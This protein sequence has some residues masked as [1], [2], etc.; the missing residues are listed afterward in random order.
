MFL[1]LL[2][3]ATLIAHV[4]AG[5]PKGYEEAMLELQKA[6][7]TGND[8]AVAASVEDFVNLLPK[9]YTFYGVGLTTGDR[10]EITFVKTEQLYGSIYQ[11]PINPRKMIEAECVYVADKYSGSVALIT[12]VPTTIKTCKHSTYRSYLH[13]HPFKPIITLNQNI[14]TSGVVQKDGEPLTQI[15]PQEVSSNEVK[16]FDLARIGKN[17]LQDH[18]MHILVGHVY[19]VSYG[20]SKIK[21]FVVFAEIKASPTACKITA[22]YKLTDAM[23]SSIQTSMGMTCTGN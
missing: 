23:V 16:G 17:Y 5:S 7:D 19:S 15:T 22:F 10:N 9:K 11:I 8:D 18:D 2:L 21:Q 3:T 6:V 13:S 4:L 14:E 12:E 20:T 1:K